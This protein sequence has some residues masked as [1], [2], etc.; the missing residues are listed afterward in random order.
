MPEV[1]E[2][3]RRRDEKAEVSEEGLKGW[4]RKEPVK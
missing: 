4:K 1:W 2:W 3:L